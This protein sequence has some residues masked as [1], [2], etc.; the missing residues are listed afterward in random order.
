MDTIFH[1]HHLQSDRLDELTHRDHFRHVRN[2]DSDEGTICNAPKSLSYRKLQRLQVLQEKE[3]RPMRLLVYRNQLDC[4]GSR[5][6]ESPR[7]VQRGDIGERQ[8]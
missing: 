6:S 3:E 7:S 5:G 4:R 8:A 1:V 2:S